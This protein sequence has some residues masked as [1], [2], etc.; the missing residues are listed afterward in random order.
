MDLFIVESFNA[1]MTHFDHLINSDEFKIN[2]KDNES[3][4][5]AKRELFEHLMKDTNPSGQA[6]VH[7]YNL[8]IALDTCKSIANYG[9]KDKFTISS[10][11]EE[12]NSSTC[13]IMSDKINNFLKKSNLEQ[14]INKIGH[15]K[16][17]SDSCCIFGVDPNQIHQIE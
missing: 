13:K 14:R 1:I 2:C 11:I 3:V 4:K 8:S 6:L 9:K 5:L 15:N 17:K 10:K 12:A 7:F 16:K